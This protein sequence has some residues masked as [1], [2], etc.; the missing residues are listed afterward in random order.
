MKT[1]ISI[2]L[3]LIF[4]CTQV[5]A[6]VNR[7]KLFDFRS[8]TRNNPPRITA[9]ANKKFL[10][11]IFPKYFRDSRYCKE[12]VDT[13]GADDYLAAMRKAG[14]IVPAIIDL[15]TG[16]FT[17]AGEDQMA[18]IISV[19]E[20]NASHADNFG[21]KRL[22]IFAGNRLVLNADLLLS[23]SPFPTRLDRLNCSSNMA[24]MSKKSI[25]YQ[26]SRK[27]RKSPA[28]HSPVFGLARTQHPSQT[29][30]SFAAASG[31]AK[32]PWGSNSTG[33]NVTLP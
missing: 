4:A 26:D 23:R 27:E 32:K 19:G 2:A 21:S 14:Q 30:A 5:A 13:S 18:L 10:S 33:T 12:D 24:L 28:S 29:P 16:S 25:I 7:E 9:A 17:A 8:E 6:Q 1:L 20:C 3:V 22:A 11:A 15:A 31:K